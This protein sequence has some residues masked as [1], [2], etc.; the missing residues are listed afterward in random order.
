VFHFEMLQK[1]GTP[2][3]KWKPRTFITVSLLFLAPAFSACENPAA[4]APTESSFQAALVALDTI[5]LV[6][7]VQTLASDVYMGRAPASPGERHTIDYLEEGFL[8]LGLRPGGENGLF[9]QE[10]PLVS[11][12]ADPEMSLTVQDEGWSRSFAYGSEFVATTPEAR[13]SSSLD[14]SEMVFVGYGI[15]APEY[16]WNDYDGVDVEGKTVVALVNDPGFITK[17]PDFFQG[18]AMTYYG[19]WTY[20]YEEAGRQGAAGVL[21]IHETEPAAYPWA[22]VENGWTGPQ[23]IL[24]ESQALSPKADVEG[25]ISYSIASD[26]FSRAD[27]DLEELKTRAFEPGF[28]AVPMNLTAS[29]EIQNTLEPSVSH[30]FLARLDGSLRP[31]EVILY[32]GHWDHFGIDPTLEGDSIFNGARDNASGI[33]AMLEI[34]EAFTRLEPAPQRSIVFLAT[35]AEEQGLLG[36]EYYA[37]NPVYPLHETVA[38]I[39]IDALSIWGA[40]HDYVVVGHGKSELD[41]YAR[42][43]AEA[44]DRVV[45]PNPE[46]EKGSFYRSDHFPLA[47][48]GIPAHYGGAGFDV[49]GQ[50]EEYGQAQSDAWTAEHYHRPSDEYSDDWALGGALQDMHLWFR[51]GVDLGYSSDFP[52][53]HEGTEF[54]AVREATFEEAG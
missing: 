10:V 41:E 25:W 40:T 7:H 13:E 8:A 42:S 26:I 28:R 5:E 23:F 37:S 15:V 3:R 22:T 32:M 47:K 1:E 51:M 17:D 16:G 33:A 46:P 35:T 54:K 52:T 34:A 24:A 44:Q 6:G 30:N 9:T 2:M 14:A 39:N 21:L 48:R 20:K 53:W 31:D 50:G 45:K 19:R 36:S 27:L 4:D 11:I 43:A 29:V 38:A 12:T 49:M 18:N